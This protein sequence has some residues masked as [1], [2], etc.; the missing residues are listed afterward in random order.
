M[1]APSTGLKSI[2]ALASNSWPPCHSA[3]GASSEPERLP[4]AK[5]GAVV[6]VGGDDRVLEVQGS[7]HA[8]AHRFLSIISA[9]TSVMAASST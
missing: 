2:Q 4:P 6:S 5:V 7:L 9:A 8:L 1:Q 3:A